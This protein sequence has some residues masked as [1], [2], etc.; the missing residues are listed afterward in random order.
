MNEMTVTSADAFDIRDWL[1]TELMPPPLFH[2][3]IYS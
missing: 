1:R 2:L 3:F